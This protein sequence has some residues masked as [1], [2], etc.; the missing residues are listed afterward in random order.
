MSLFIVTDYDVR[1]IIIIIIIIIV[2]VHSMTP[3]VYMHMTRKQWWNDINKESRSVRSKP[4]LLA[5]TRVCQLEMTRVIAGH[6]KLTYK[7]NGGR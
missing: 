1:F 4:V 3:T 2:V 5:W 6:I 7:I